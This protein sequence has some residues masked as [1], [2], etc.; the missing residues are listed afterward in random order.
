MSKSL[1]E[2]QKLECISTSLVTLRIGVNR[3]LAEPAS[4]SLEKLGEHLSRAAF[5][6]FQAGIRAVAPRDRHRQH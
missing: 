4:K 6:A 3:S 1:Y 2:L 5:G